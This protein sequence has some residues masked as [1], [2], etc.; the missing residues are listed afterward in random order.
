MVWLVLY[1]H[2][3]RLV[4]PLRVLDSPPNGTAAQRGRVGARVGARV[5][6]RVRAR[7]WVRARVIRAP[8]AACRDNPNPNPNPNPNLQV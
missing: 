1:A 7:V 8:S 5:R 3:L 2:E 6:A 4:H